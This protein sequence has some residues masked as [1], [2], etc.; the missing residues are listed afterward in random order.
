MCRHERQAEGAMSTCEKLV[1]LVSQVNREEEAAVALR[2]AAQEFV[3][4]VD[5]AGLINLSNGVQ[6]GATSWFVKASERLEWLR[7]TIARAGTIGAQPDLEPY[8]ASA[9][10]GDRT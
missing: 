8:D 9:T 2:E 6:L 10:S 1:S 5:A 3:D 4:I 7:R